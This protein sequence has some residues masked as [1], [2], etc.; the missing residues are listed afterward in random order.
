MSSPRR[1]FVVI[2][3]VL[4]SC[5]ASSSTASTSSTHCHIGPS[6][7]SNAE[8]TPVAKDV[9]WLD[10]EMNRIPWPSPFN[11]S[12][13]FLS[14]VRSFFTASTNHT[15]DDGSEA[16]RTSIQKGA[17]LL[18]PTLIAIRRLLHRHPELMYR[19]RLTGQIVQRILREM[20]IHNVSVGWGKNIHSQFYNVDGFTGDDE[21]YDGGGFGIVV[22]IG[23]GEPPCVLIRADMDALPIVEKTPLPPDLEGE[24]VGAFRSQNYGKMHACG[25]DAHMTMLL[26]ATYMIHSLKQ[27]TDND[28]GNDNNNQYAFP[29]TIRIIFQPAEEGGAGAKRM[30]EEGVLTR[31]PPPSYA[32]A[33]HVWP[34][35]PSGEIGF[36]SGPMLAAADMF[37]LQIEGVGGHAAFPH[38]VVDPIVAA[39]SIVLNAQTLVSRGMNPLESGVVSVTQV[40]AGDG[41]FNVVPAKAVLRGT[42]R[43]LS[44]EALLE[45]R[46]GLVRIAENTAAAHG[47]VLT[48]STFSRDHYPVTM[49]DGGLYPFAARVAGMVARGGRVTKVDPTMGAEDFAF[50]AQGVPSAFFFLGQ[51][52]NDD[53]EGG[54]NCAGTCTGKVPTNLGLHHPAFNLDE[55]VM[56]RGVELFVNLALRALHELKTEA[57]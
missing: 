51:G 38:L 55:D 33:M 37:T 48:S 15:N 30:S 4:S 9:N 20:G 42:I 2:L 8:C 11:E 40:E 35:L 36:R 45:L 3:S 21:D 23:S 54:T 12:P 31:R 27:Q 22:D 17:A 10:T 18:Q 53:E 5:A 25:H 57:R 56:S 50:L 32:F 16:L 44:D 41:A 13:S 14:A 28:N 1:I 52:G 29:G 49:N 43:A 34:T 46:R 26:G 39:S 7:S 6:S 24:D 19:E 47:C